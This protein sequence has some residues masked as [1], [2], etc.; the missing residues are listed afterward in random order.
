MTIVERDEERLTERLDSAVD[1]K[2]KLSERQL[3]LIQSRFEVR[4]I[5]LKSWSRQ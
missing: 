1:E 3:I 4:G 2:R 5:L